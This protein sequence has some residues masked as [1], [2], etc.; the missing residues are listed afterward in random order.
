MYKLKL[1]AA[2]FC[3]AMI[4][5]AALAQDPANAS[6]S[7]TSCTLADGREISLR[8]ADSSKEPN[9]N[10]VWAPG[11]SPMYLFTQTDL[12]LHGKSIPAGAYSVYLTGKKNDWTLIVNKD[13]SAGAKYDEKQDLVRGPM[14]MGKLGSPNKKLQVYFVHAEPKTCNLRIYYQDNGYWAEF[15]EQ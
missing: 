6:Q 14:E 11:G 7:S 1:C 10:G 13:V 3:F 12:T 15:K 8:Y 2:W 4:A 5:V 9:M